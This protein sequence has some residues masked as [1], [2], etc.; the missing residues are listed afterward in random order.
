MFWVHTLLFRR[1]A[2][3]IELAVVVGTDPFSR[4]VVVVDDD[5]AE[6]HQSALDPRRL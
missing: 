5:D 4:H 1:G 6:L 3:S 2:A